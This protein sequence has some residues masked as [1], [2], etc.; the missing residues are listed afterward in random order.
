MKAITTIV[1]ICLLGSFAACQGQH[2]KKE[3]EMTSK[4]EVTS[5]DTTKQMN[6]LDE[7]TKILS[8]VFTMG[9][10]S[11]EE[12]PFVGTTNYLE[13]IEKTEMPESQRKE[14]RELYKLYE[15]G[16]DPKKKAEFEVKVNKKLKEAMDKSMSESNR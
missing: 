6:L 5:S 12:N 14:L 4:K 1:T 8:Q 13:L 9:G 10:A 11:E 2:E 3:L 7:Q 15:L 16:L